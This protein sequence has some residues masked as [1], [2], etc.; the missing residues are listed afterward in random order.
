ME[1]P[2]SPATEPQDWLGR[3]M[4]TVY[5][6][7]GCGSCDATKVW[8]KRQGFDFLQVDVSTDDAARAFVER[9]GYT[10]LPVVVA[11]SA[12]WSGFRINKLRELLSQ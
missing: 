7:P 8:L 11:G 9:L 3:L 6:R 10:S 5:T 2:L 1:E 4:I 12:H